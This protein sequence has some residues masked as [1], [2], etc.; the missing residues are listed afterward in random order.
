VPPGGGTVLID[1]LNMAVSG[2]AEFAAIAASMM[3]L[4][5]RA[6][7]GAGEDVMGD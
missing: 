7:G 6:V 5:K 3:G 2:A 1:E 4:K